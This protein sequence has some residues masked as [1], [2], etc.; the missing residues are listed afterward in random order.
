MVNCDDY[1]IEGPRVYAREA[2]ER[3]LRTLPQWFGIESALVD[4]VR[5]TERLPT[6]VL[7]QDGICVA[8]VSL[9]K[10]FNHSWEIHCIAVDARW[11]GKGYGSAIL[12]HAEGWMAGQGARWL[13]VKTLAA[14]HPSPEYAQ[15]RAF[16]KRMGYEPLQEFPTLWSE[17]NPCLVM[18]KTIG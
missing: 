11:R 4:Y 12:R 8:F 3:I 5:E 9:A 13:Q 7:R 2:C 18:V 6:F 17:E 1:Q 15:T 14:S 10:H 16:Y